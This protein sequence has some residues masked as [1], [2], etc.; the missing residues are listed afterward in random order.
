MFVHNI[1]TKEKKLFFRFPYFFLSGSLKYRIINHQANQGSMVND[2][3]E[4]CWH[5]YT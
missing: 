3:W 1:Q 2:T 4:I 5:I